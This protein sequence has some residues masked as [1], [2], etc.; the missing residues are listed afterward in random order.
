MQ[1]ANKRVY[2]CVCNKKMA[3]SIPRSRSEDVLKVK[4]V[5]AQGGGKDGSTLSASS[6]ELRSML[7]STLS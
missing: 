4:P 1:G 5:L 7:V 3:V 2:C 6:P